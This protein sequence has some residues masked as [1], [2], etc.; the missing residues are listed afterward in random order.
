MLSLFPQILF[1]APLGTTLLR[2]VAGVYVLYIAYRVAADTEEYQKERFPIVGHAPSWLLWLGAI[3]TFAIG[4]LLVI[5]LYTQA[6]AIL[7]GLTALKI[8][9]VDRW[10]G[11]IMPL[12]TA[13]AILLFF[14][15]LSLLVSGPG[16]YAFDLPL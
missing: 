1:L 14:V 13:A 4:L 3:I 9:I 2:I 16:I 7:A 11:R 8:A 6:A 12:S 10:Y 15:C 5:G